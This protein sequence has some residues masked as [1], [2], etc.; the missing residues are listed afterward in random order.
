LSREAV[1]NNSI[2]KF[3]E[4]LPKPRGKKVKNIKETSQSIDESFLEELDEIRKD[5]A[6]SFKKNNPHLSS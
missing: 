5:L 2:E 4:S 6:K 1:A 3:V